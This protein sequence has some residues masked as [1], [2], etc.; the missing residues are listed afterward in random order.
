MGPIDQL[1]TLDDALLD[2]LMH[3]SPRTEDD[4]AQM[5]KIFAMRTQLDAAINNLVARRLQLAVANL[6]AQTAQ[7]ETAVQ[8]MKQT[9]KSIDDLQKVLTIV[10]AVVQ[11]AAQLVALVAA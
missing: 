2:W 4:R 1:L 11:V 5:L 10:G 9:S 6:P 3:A 8:S 7:L